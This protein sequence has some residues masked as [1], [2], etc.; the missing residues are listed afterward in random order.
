[1]F[2]K[3]VE[4][5]PLRHHGREAAS[6]SKARQLAKENIV[7]AYAGAYAAPAKMIFIFDGTFLRS[8]F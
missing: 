1:L 2:R 7:A 8:A 4:K 3:E 5:I 6:R